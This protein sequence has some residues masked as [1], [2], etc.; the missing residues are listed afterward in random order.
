MAKREKRKGCSIQHRNEVIARKVHER[1]VAVRNRGTI[2]MSS[3]G[4]TKKEM[5]E[6]EKAFFGRQ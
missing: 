4:H 6:K 5:S 3:L 2:G 1:K